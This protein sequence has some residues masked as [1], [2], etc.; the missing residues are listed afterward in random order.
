M[1]NW[2][3]IYVSVAIV[4]LGSCKQQ[5]DQPLEFTETGVSFSLLDSNAYLRDTIEIEK[6]NAVFTRK[7][8]NP[9]N[10][11]LPKSYTGRKIIKN[12]AALSYDI[13]Y[14]PGNIVRFDE[15]DSNYVLVTLKAML[16]NS[17]NPT[18]E[19]LD[20]EILYSNKIDDR[21]SF[22]ASAL[23]A[24]L[25]VE[26]NQL[27]ELVIQD[28]AKSVAPDNL[29]DEEKIRENLMKIDSE[30]RKDY[31]FIKSV[32][33][34]TVQNRKYQKSDF[35]AKVNLNYLTANGTVYSTNE[36]F[37]KERVVSMDLVS[38]NDIL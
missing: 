36:K 28:V 33:L 1:K 3:I 9:I 2:I 6:E 18:A 10:E 38:L 34:T 11:E 24:G 29:I 37:S 22:N 7:Q 35:S 14:L 16:K 8:Q 31:Y 32:L 21:A 17:V 25:S 15:A 4:A 5:R 27:L 12:T 26:K 13:F 20:N 19:S 23:I 30:R